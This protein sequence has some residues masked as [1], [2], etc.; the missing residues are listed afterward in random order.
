MH[1]QLAFVWFRLRAYKVDKHI[2]RAQVV[3]LRFGRATDAVC[4][5]LD[6][7]VSVLLFSLCKVSNGFKPIIMYQLRKRPTRTRSR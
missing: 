6:D 5:Q 4:L 3:V 7:I 2:S 1:E